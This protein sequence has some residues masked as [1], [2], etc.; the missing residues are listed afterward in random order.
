MVRCSHCGDPVGSDVRWCPK[1][2]AAASWHTP[3]GGGEVP[4]GAYLLVNLPGGKVRKAYL[5]GPVVRLG[6]SKECEVVLDDPR[7][8]RVHATLELRGGT[9]RLADARS[10]GGTF[11]D[12]RPVH[13]PTPLGA[14]STIR[15][16]RDLEN[17]VILVYHHHEDDVPEGGR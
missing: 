2:G 17:A 12:D 8:S 11:L 16:G 5:D 6:R 13:E 10:T 7:V 15:L 3:T 14:G 9:Y 4:P 1:C